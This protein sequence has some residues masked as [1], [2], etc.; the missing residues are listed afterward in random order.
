MGKEE[1]ER[2]LRSPHAGI[3]PF[4]PTAG[5]P[6]QIAQNPPRLRS[7]EKGLKEEV[8][9][10]P[11][12]LRFKAGTV[13]YRAGYNAAGEP[14]LPK[15]FREADDLRLDVLN[16][17]RDFKVAESS[18]GEGKRKARVVK[19]L[20]I[21]QYGPIIE[22]IVERKAGE[23]RIIEERRFVSLLDRSLPRDNPRRRWAAQRE[24]F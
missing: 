24:N 20:G 19:P 4:D 18:M 21:T 12:T 11:K 8:K 15:D 3:Y 6:E 2:R 14:I 1:E 10:T 22:V 16:F 23:G 7:W 17:E 9:R 13:L 5:T